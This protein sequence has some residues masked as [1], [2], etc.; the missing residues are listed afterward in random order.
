MTSS[1]Q[2]K[3]ANGWLACARP[4]PSPNFNERPTEAAPELIVIHGISLP[5]GEYG[6]PYIEALFTNQLNPADHAYFSEVAHLAVSAHFLIR[7]DGAIVQFVS[8]EH[9]AWHAGESCWERRSNCN[10]F[11]IGIE[12]EGCDEERYERLQYRALA[13]LIRA[14]RNQYPAIQHD[15]IVGHSDIAPTRK[16]DPGPAFDWLQL[17]QLLG[18]VKGEQG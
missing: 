16:T 5:P 1:D 12:V 2:W 3:F 8:T 7:R 14:V 9:R 13:Q 15:A 6:G 11:S 4:V 10:D 18:A 17:K